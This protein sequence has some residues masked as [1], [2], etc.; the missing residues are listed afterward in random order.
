MLYYLFYEVLRPYFKALNVFRYITVRTAYASLTA[1]FHRAGARAVGDSRTARNANRPVHP[2]R[3]AKEPQ[4]QGRHTH[5]GRSANR[6]R[7]GGSHFALGGFEKRLRSA[8]AGRDGCIW[9]NWFR[10][11]LSKSGAPHTTKGSRCAEKLS[12]R[13]LPAFWRVSFCLILLTRGVYSTQ[14]IIPF[15]KNF[16]PDLVVHSL[17]WAQLSL[18]AGICAI[19]SFHHSRGG[20]I[21]ECRESYRRARR[22]RYRLHHYCGRRA[23][24]SDLSDQQRAIRQLS[25]H[26]IHSACRRT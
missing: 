20:W 15:F 3:R 21:V 6:N 14:L 12:S 1:L 25:R 11:R 2:R 10:R 22:P 8:R 13:F 23:H 7:H 19:P 26:P 18:A 16:H 4:G 24:H 9:R 5:D 17:A